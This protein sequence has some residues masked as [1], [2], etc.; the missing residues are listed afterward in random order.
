MHKVHCFILLPTLFLAFTLYG[1]EWKERRE[2]AVRELFC[3][4]KVHSFRH[5]R[6]E[7]CNFLVKKL[8]ESAADGSPVDLSKALFWLTAS[9]LFRVA[10]GQNFHES[11]FID[12][13]KIKELVFEAE[14]ALGSFTC[15]DFF[16]VAGLGWLVDWLSGQHKRRND[17]FFKLDDLFQ[18]VIDDHLTP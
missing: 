15:S 18:R 12:K 10:F 3:L 6:E 11:K 9:I 17:V 13:E 8:S 14:T 5:I 16:P 7:E 4:K 2:L 1:E